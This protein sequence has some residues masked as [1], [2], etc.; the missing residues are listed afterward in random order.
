MPISDD[1]QAGRQDEEYLLEQLQLSVTCN[2]VTIFV[3]LSIRR[4][5][6]N[7]I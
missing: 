1:S 4:D 5:R 6:K 7:H 3:S 2:A